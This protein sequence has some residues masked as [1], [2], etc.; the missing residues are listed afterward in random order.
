MRI[1][2]AIKWYTDKYLT[3]WGDYEE[4]LE[5]FITVKVLEHTLYQ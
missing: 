4:R 2:Y 1:V 3:L 5:I